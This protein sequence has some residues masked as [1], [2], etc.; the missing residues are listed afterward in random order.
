M[1]ML[2]QVKNNK[3]NGNSIN[4]PSIQNRRPAKIGK[5]VPKN[6]T[7]IHEEIVAL[8]ITGMSNK[9]LAER[10]DKTPEYISMLL[11]TPQAKIIKRKA[12]NDLSTS[13]QEF[14]KD[15]LQRTQAKAM[16]R[17]SD[18][19]D[20]DVLAETNPFAVVDRSFKLLEKTGV[21][22][23]EREKGDINVAGD[24]NVSNTQVNVT[25]IKELTEGLDRL[26]EIAVIHGPVEPVNVISPTVE[27]DD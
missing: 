27:D 21:I 18:L 4:L 19:L 12:L 10:F 20:D 1:L 22:A 2:P 5:W 17:I 3:K 14:Q 11:N 13:Y 6:W 26:Q 23:R 24:L 9:A 15:R 16:E 7:P 25:Q 8:K